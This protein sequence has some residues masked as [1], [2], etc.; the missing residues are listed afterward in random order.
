MRNAADILR[1]GLP[2][3]IVLGGDAVRT[4]ALENA[5]RIAAATGARLIAQGANARISRGRG[6][7]PVDRIPYVVDTALKALAGTRHVILCGLRKPVTFFAYPNKPTTP[8]SAD[9]DI[10]V[11]AR[12]DQDS[13][14]ALARLADELA[15]PRVAIP[16]P[17]GRP[18]PARGRLTPESVAATLSALLPEHAVVT[19]EAVTFGRGFFPFTYAAEPHDW[20]NSTGG[21]I[22]CG[23]P[24]ATGAAVG[25][26]GRRVVALQADGSAMYTLQ[27]LW[28][29]ARE[30]LDVTTVLLSN[31]KYQILLGELANV[32]ANPG[33]TALDMLDLGSPDL[34]WTKLTA[35]MG[36]EAARA[37]TCERFADLFAQ[38]NARQGP[39]LIELASH[40]GSE[41]SALL[42]G[43][44]SSSP[45][46]PF[47]ISS[48][49]L[50]IFKRSPMPLVVAV[51]PFAS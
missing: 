6:R 17:G 11:L 43:S 32:G 29:Q 51:W 45:P 20:L 10:H 9:A 25:A 31:R 28:T 19:D 37:D 8:I 35:G 14:E 49:A 15:A 36:V 2:T 34:D 33:R 40:W 13:A 16:D 50:K 1:R 44:T 5:H 42:D 47:G 38:A 24:L 48:S 12:T 46:L 18:E 41:S 30:N 23:P 4:E 3:L 21:A 7:V 26:P 39:F 27:A 22:G